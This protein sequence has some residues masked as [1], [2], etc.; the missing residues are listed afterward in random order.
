MTHASQASITRL[1][2]E[3]RNE[4]GD[5]RAALDALFPLVYNELRALAH[6]Q[7]HGW[8]GDYT[9]NTTALVHEAYLKLVDQSHA[10]W[11]SRAHFCAVAAS[12]MRH[13][14]IDYARRR[15][16]EKRGGNVQKLSFDE[17]QTLLENESIGSD[18]LADVLEIL[19]EALER[20]ACLDERQSRVVEC[21]FFGG[22]TIAETA[23][24][25]GIA[26]ATA[27]RDWRMARAWL[28]REIQQVMQD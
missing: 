21:R 9:V 6:W 24:A 23:A 14:L 4:Q 7:R 22:M 5:R 18:A 2:E 28:A 15:R 26:T 27:N 8:H 10:D 1:L 19:H 25:L 17:V 12:A 13:L 16:A 20:L 11:T 3:L